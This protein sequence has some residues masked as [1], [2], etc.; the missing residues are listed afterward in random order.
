[1]DNPRLDLG[2]ST[3][4]EFAESD[5]DLA[6]RA[7]TGDEQA[8]ER[9]MRRYNQRLFRL[10]ISIAS[11]ASEA[12]DVLQESYVRAF[13]RLSTYTGEGDLGAW[14]ARIVR[15]EAIDRLRHKG[16][17]S[18]RITLESD[19]YTEPDDPGL[20]GSARADEIEFN[21]EIAAERDDMKRILE[22]AIGSLP[23]QF[24]A[25]FMLREVEG[26]SV[27]E[28]AAYLDI[29]QATVKTRDHR[30][31]LLLRACLSQQLDGTLPRTYRFLGER[32]DSIVRTVLARITGSSAGGG[33]APSPR[34][35]SAS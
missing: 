10:A 32:C 34:D 7:A 19:F 29:P 27:E 13:Y 25:V 11:D 21:P 8:F 24:R 33:T 16:S 3:P 28:T 20:S 5:L 22:D 2:S 12:E 26:L 31:R 4:A 1:M 23:V 18:R 35:R 6:R 9:I 17:R 15:N 30:A 14:L